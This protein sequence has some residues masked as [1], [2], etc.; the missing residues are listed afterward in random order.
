MIPVGDDLRRQ[1]LL[2][3]RRVSEQEYLT[4][5]LGDVR[6]VPLI[7]A[8]GWE[9]E[10]TGAAAPQGAEKSLSALIYESSEHFATVDHANLDNLLAR[11]G[12]S[13]LVLLGEAPHGTAEFY[14]M[15][16]RITQ[17]LI[18]KKGFTGIAVEADWPDAAHIDH[19]V[20]GTSPD[21]L[22]ESSAFSRFPTWMRST[23]R[24]RR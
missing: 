5:D 6:F 19:F 22:P 12:D 13:R 16:A 20:R 10:T 24:P 8:A 17:E 1:K 15:R 9:D 4:E 3:V 14:E 21:P 18:L 11:T 23:P 7:G 2:R